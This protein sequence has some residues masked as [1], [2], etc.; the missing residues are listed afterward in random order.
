[1]LK[2]LFL[3]MLLLTLGISSA[4]AAVDGPTGKI[5]SVEGSQV[6]L[7]VAGEMPMWARSGG[8]LKAFDA[9]GKIVVRRGKIAKVEGST[10]IFTSAEAKELKVGKLYKLAKARVNEG[11]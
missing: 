1:M 6:T 3:P 11:C 2:Y 9:E 10:L 7:Q 8:Y 5:M 4:R